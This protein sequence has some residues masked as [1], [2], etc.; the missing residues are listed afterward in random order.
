MWDRIV[1]GMVISFV[2]RQ[3]EKFGK[4]TDWVMLKS[5]ADVAVRAFVPGTW[6]DDEAVLLV[7]G[8]IDAC[9][10]ALGDGEDWDKLLHALAAQDWT[11]ALGALLVERND[12]HRKRCSTVWRP[13]ATN[14]RLLAALE[15]HTADQTAA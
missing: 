15:Y 9:K 6:F 8:A 12:G 10:T 4:A 13:T 5:E 3:I 11:A 1:M 7:N 14:P 2:L